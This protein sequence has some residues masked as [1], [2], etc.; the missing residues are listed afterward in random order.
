MV[1]STASTAWIQLKHSCA[2][3]YFVLGLQTI[4]AQY[5][6]HRRRR[7]QSPGYMLIYSVVMFCLATIWYVCGTVF[8]EVVDVE[9]PFDTVLAKALTSC[10]PLAVMRTLTHT[11]M[12]W[13]GDGLFVSIGGTDL[14]SGLMRPF[15]CGEH[16]CCGMGIGWSWPSLYWP[17]SPP[18]VGTGSSI[19][20]ICFSCNHRFG[21]RPRI[22][23]PGHCRRRPNRPAQNSAR[24]PSLLWHFHWPHHPYCKPDHY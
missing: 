11:L 16:G 1:R 15:S 23:M 8:G 4:L 13:M 24:R 10:Q 2:G 3:M 21:C 22:D 18:S 19:N 20:R 14:E 6:Q 12:M 5:K 7:G 9:L 17:I